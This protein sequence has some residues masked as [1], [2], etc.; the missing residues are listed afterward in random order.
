MPQ[1]GES[2]PRIYSP[3]NRVAQ[4]Y[5]QSLGSLFVVS[6]DSQ[7]RILKIESKNRYKKCKKSAYMAQNGFKRFSI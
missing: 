1:P 5:P 3:R 2:G 4:L 6:Y 7:R